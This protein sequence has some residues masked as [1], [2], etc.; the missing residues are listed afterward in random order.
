MSFRRTS[1]DLLAPLRPALSRG[2]RMRPGFLVV[3]TKRG[4]STSAY[5]WISQHPKVAPC[6]TRKGTHYFDVNHGRGFAWYASGFEKPRPEW[7]IT[8]EASPYYMFHPLAPERIA[9]ELPEARLIV[10]LRDPVT[11]AWSHYQYELARGDESLPF[12]VALAREAERLDGEEERMRRDQGYESFAHRHHSY[13]HRGHYAEQLEHL[14]DLFPTG[15]VLVL[16]SEA[17]F[18]DPNGQL[19]RVWDFLDLPQ[20]RL[21]GLQPMKAG[22]YEAMPEGTAHLLADYFAPHNDKL[23]TMPG[24]DFRWEEAS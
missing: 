20:V 9:R 16:Q 7:T 4:G 3:G 15:Q 12:D 21:D 22:S 10:V 2:A 1:A 5:H 14:Y 23:Y 19:A 18:A 24:I 11:R 13:L 8:G 6:L 17:M